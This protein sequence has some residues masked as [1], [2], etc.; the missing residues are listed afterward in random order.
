MCKVAI[1]LG[2]CLSIILLWWSRKWKCRESCRIL[3]N[4][5]RKNHIILKYAFSIITLAF[6]SLFT[7]EWEQKSYVSFFAHFDIKAAL[8]QIRPASLKFGRL[9]DKEDVVCRIR[10]TDNELR[11]MQMQGYSGIYWFI[12]L[13]HIDVYSTE[14]THSS[15]C[16]LRSCSVRGELSQQGEK[17][18]WHNCHWS[19]ESTG[20]AELAAQTGR[21]LQH[22]PIKN[23]SMC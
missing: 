1:R 13:R 18:K 21:L 4:C 2:K 8:L 20:I 3:Q 17:T 16:R 14:L 15:I 11:D 10:R 23:N 12:H 19:T 6:S 9:F 5:A 22:C 7:M